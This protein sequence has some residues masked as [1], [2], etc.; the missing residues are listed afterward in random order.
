M[1]LEKYELFNYLSTDDIFFSKKRIIF[2]WN[3]LCKQLDSVRSF[4][5]YV[6]LEFAIKDARRR[7]VLGSFHAY[8]LKMLLFKIQKTLLLL[9]L[10]FELSSSILLLSKLWLNKLHTENSIKSFKSKAAMMECFS[11]TLQMTEK[12][13]RVKISQYEINQGIIWISIN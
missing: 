8:C 10:Y 2:L 5:A 4:A 9:V 13:G 7:D 3:N 6:L 12:C 11:R 1:K